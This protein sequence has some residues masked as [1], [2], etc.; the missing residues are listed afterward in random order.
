VSIT[1]QGLEKL[2]SARSTLFYSILGVGLFSGSAA[3]AQTF[4]L[5]DLTAGANQE[6]TL[7]TSGVP[8]GTYTSYMVTLDWSTTGVPP[9]E[10][11]SR[12]ADFLLTAGGLADPQVLYADPLLAS[13]ATFGPAPISLVWHEF[14]INEYVAG[15]P[16]IFTYRQQFVGTTAQ[17]G[18]VEIQ[19]L[20]DTGRTFAELSL[21]TLAAGVDVFGDTA[22]SS[23]NIA[24]NDGTYLTG[25]D[26]W[27]GADDVYTINWG[28]GELTIEASF[29]HDLG[30]LDLFL[31]EELGRDPLDGSTSS[32]DLE[33]ITRDLAPGTYYAV[34]DGWD[35]DSNS[36][37]IV[38]IPEPGSATVLLLA[39][40]MLIRRRR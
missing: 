12:E 35:G 11:N 1:S 31:Y 3:Q 29:D 16:L 19:L 23:D 9:A 22:T 37:S 14:L 13:N 39:S 20:Q 40:G 36:Y 21:G 30:D 17:W 6:I 32:D 7:D 18:N 34:L 33:S 24:G 5:G 4:N 2:M 28:G 15:D 8:A 26:N 10:P 27:N 25:D 38:L